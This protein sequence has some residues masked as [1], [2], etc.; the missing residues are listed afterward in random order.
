M[1]VQLAT[2]KTK[3]EWYYEL[4]VGGTPSRGLYGHGLRCA[5]RVARAHRAGRSAVRLWCRRECP[6]ECILEMLAVLLR[7]NIKYC[8]KWHRNGCAVVFWP[9]ERAGA[10]D[11]ARFQA[12]WTKIC[13][14]NKALERERFGRE[15]WTAIM[16]STGAAQKALVEAAI[17]AGVVERVEAAAAPGG[18][19]VGREA[20]RGE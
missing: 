17:E 16:R 4:A 10:V 20:E 7:R 11:V 14:H 12:R 1:W 19:G 15:V 2:V 3:A 18:A 13:E 9:G 6:T 5:V 8:V